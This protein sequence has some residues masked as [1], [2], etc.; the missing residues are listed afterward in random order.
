[1]AE[2]DTGFV[3]VAAL[4]DLPPGQLRAV[5]VGDISICLAHA[6]GRIYAFKNNC[7]HRDYPLDTGLLDDDQIECSWHGARYDLETGRPTRLP[8]IRPLQMFEVRIE[9]GDVYVEVEEDY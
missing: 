1:M 6:D 3:R 8:A 7:T 9:D 5:D 2:V 4:T